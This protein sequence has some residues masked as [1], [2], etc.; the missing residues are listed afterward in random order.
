MEPT[1]YPYVTLNA[2]AYTGASEALLYDPPIEEFSVVRLELGLKGS[3][4]TFEPIQGPSIVLV[5]QGEGKISV[6]PKTEDLKV[7]CFYSLSCSLCKGRE[8]MLI[9][10]YS[11]DTSS[12]LVRRQNWLSRA[13]ETSRSSRSRRSASWADTMRSCRAALVLIVRTEAARTQGSRLQ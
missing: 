10:D 4:A 2:K 6:G 3:K 1:P 12:L 9:C 13:R 7:W 8:R 11:L 5:T